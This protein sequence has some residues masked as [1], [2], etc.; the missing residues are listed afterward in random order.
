MSIALPRYQRHAEHARDIERVARLVLGADPE[1]RRNRA[2]RIGARS[3]EGDPRRMRGVP[4]QARGV[5]GNST[6][7]AELLHRIE[8]Q[9]L[10]VR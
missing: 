5:P 6:E 9:P 10:S 1:P 3:G 8:T 2:K 7:S 4:M